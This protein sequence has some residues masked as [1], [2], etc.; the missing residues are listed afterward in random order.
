[1]NN[2]DQYVNQEITKWPVKLLL[3]GDVSALGIVS[4]ALSKKYD[5][6]VLNLET[7]IR[8][9]AA[10]VVPEDPAWAGFHQRVSYF[11]NMHFILLS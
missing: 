8:Q 4:D 11:P 6:P 3:I 10:D 9:F 1:M 7:S 5:I 2:P